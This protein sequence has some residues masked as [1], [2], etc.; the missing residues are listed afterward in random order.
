VLLLINLAFTFGF[1]E[2]ISVGGHLGGLAG[3]ALGG[4]AIVA[5]ERGMLGARRV[6][7]E[8]VTLAL[9]GVVAAGGALVVA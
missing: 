6:P 7:A 4:L 8:V 2:F 1:S 5:G 3:G 9:L